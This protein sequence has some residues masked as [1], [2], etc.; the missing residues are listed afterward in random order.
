M[1]YDYLIAIALIAGPPL[2]FLAGWCAR[3]R[4]YRRE[5]REVQKT[6]HIDVAQLP[7]EFWNQR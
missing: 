7:A 5:W 4:K 1:Q 6:R 2:V 3:E